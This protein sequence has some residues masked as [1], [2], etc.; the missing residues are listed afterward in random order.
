MKSSRRARQS[1]RPLFALLVAGIFT[2]NADAQN[3][4]NPE[5]TPSPNWQLATDD[6]SLTLAVV[7][8]RPAI[9][10][11]TNP[12]QGWNWT[13]VHTE[14]PLLSRVSVGRA[15]TPMAPE[16][17][18]Q[19][20]AE[21]DSNGKKITLRFTST[22]PKLEL[23]SVWWARPGPGPVEESTTIA[24]QAGDVL[25]VYGPDKVSADMAFVAAQRSRDGR[26]PAV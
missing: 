26:G 10:R 14:F 11:L 19:D 24:N 7:N 1:Q 3:P 20:A 12:A 4:A 21:D 8:N 5:T 6:T 15:N 9:Y 18:F 25:T 17:K 2:L 22:T 16:W 23:K 13:P